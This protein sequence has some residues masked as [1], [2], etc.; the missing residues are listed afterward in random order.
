MTSGAER[1]QRTIRSPEI[2]T[3]VH[4]EHGVRCGCAGG[5]VNRLLRRITRRPCSLRHGFTVARNKLG[6]I[7]EELV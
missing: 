5:N 2:S 1:A 7:M 4:N 3:A 6:A